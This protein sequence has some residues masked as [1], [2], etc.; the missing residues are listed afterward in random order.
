[1]RT[2]TPGK[3]KAE[4][5]D[6]KNWRVHSE[7]YGTLAYLEDPYHAAPDGMVE[8]NALLMA[9]APEMLRVL[10]A[11]NRIAV[12]YGDGGPRTQAFTALYNLVKPL[13]AKLDQPA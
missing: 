7:D 13:L 11:V 4:P 9:A 12:R 5:R 1:M 2:H 10:Q 6:G 8:A 3:W